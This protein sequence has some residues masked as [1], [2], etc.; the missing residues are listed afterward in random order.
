VS[1]SSIYAFAPREQLG[2]HHFKIGGYLAGSEDSGTVQERPVNIV[3][4]AGRILQSIAFTRPRNFEV[5]DVE[6]SFF[7][8]DHWILTQRLAVDLGI[9]TEAQQISGAFRVAPRGGI[10]WTPFSTGHTVVRGG[11]GLFYDRVPLNVYAFNRYPDRIVTFYDANGQISAGPYLF[12]NTLGQS[13]VR[14]PFVSQRPIDGNFSPRSMVWS[15]QVEQPLTRLVKLRAS[16]LHNYADALVI[17][18]RVPPDPASRQGAYL[19]EG[20]GESRYQQFDILAQVRLREDRQLYFSYVRS[21]ARGDLNDFGQFL[22][23]AP[24]PV[25]RENAYGT[26]GTDLPNRFLAWGVV[27][28]PK[29]FQIAP[30]IEYRNGFPYLETDALQQYAGTPYRNRF[31]NFMSIDSR[32]SKDLK[33]NAKYSVRLSLSAFNLT[34]HFNPEAVHGNTADPAYGY[35][36]GHRGRRFTADFDFLF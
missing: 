11:F 22:G 25:I 24:S 23:I 36:F 13:R 7:G 33:L 9:R 31:P 10:A 20:T 19:L 30:L 16:Y 15:M 1:G 5:S 28:L 35:F 14:F 6:K 32:F 12:L 27:R 8:Q 18:S 29:A 26:L 21:T 34:N 4:T 17:L 3:D 2:I